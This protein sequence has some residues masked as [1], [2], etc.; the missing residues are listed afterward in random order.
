MTIYF[1]PASV[2]MV[3]MHRSKKSPYQCRRGKRAGPK[4]KRMGADSKIPP[5]PLRFVYAFAFII[6]VGVYPA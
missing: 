2:D 5:S 3:D 1:I 6:V 4:P